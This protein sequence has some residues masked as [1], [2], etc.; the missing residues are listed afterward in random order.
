MLL[1]R[2]VITIKSQNWYLWF[3]YYDIDSAKIVTQKMF[4]L[5]VTTSNSFNERAGL[6]LKWNNR[7]LTPAPS[8]DFQLKQ[9][10]MHNRNPNWSHATIEVF[11]ISMVG[12]KRPQIDCSKKDYSPLLIANSTLHKWRMAL[13]LPKAHFL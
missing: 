9:S 6:L 13:I 5:N 7:W 4:D 1:T 11:P 10:E 2:S 8:C 3:S 12:F